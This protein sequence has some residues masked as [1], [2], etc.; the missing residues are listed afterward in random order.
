[1]AKPA[2]VSLPENL[3]IMSVDVLHEQLEA[4]LVDSHDV[5]FDAAAV[6][7]VDTAG[8]Q[9]LFAFIRSMEKNGASCSWKSA[10]EL[11][12]DASEQLGLK[13]HLKLN[14]LN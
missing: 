12:I 13:S 3:T 7:R 4:L 11:L 10:S 14:S 6:S 1:M 2:V 5:S 9:L 8:L